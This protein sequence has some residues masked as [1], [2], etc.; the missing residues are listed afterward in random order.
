MVE[1]NTDELLDRFD[2][3]ER[4]KEAGSKLV[5]LSPADIEEVGPGLPA[6]EVASI[7]DPP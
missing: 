3:Q 5:P 7:S 6:P 1:V 2:M 4:L